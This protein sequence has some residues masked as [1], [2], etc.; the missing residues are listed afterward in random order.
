M[1]LIPNYISDFSATGEKRV[2]GILQSSNQKKYENSLV[3]HSLNY[4]VQIEKKN[5]ISFQYFGETDFLIF[6]PDKGLINIEVKGGGISREGGEWYTTGRAGKNKLKKSP[7]VQATDSMKKIERY[8]E[9]QNIFIPQ[10]FLVVFPDCEFNHD[11]IEW[12][13]DNLCSGNIDQ[14]LIK[15]IINLETNY[16]LQSS[17]RFYPNQETQKKL[18]KIFRSNFE[19]YQSYHTLLKQS[20][21]E[22]NKFTEEQID[23]LD[24]FETNRMLIEGS[25]GTGKT[26]VA[27]EIAK[28]KIA[29]G[30]SVLFLNSNRLAC[31]NIKIKFHE[32]NQK[33]TN[34]IKIDTY[35]G[36]LFNNSQ[37]YFYKSN[38]QDQ[39]YL[40]ANES[41]FFKKNNILTNYYLNKILEDNS[42]VQYDCIIL[43]EI[44]NYYYYDHFYDLIDCLLKDGLRK[45]S[46]Y[47]FG[48]FQFQKL[49]L[50][51]QDLI[52]N[53][54]E[55]K[56]PR[57]NLKD[58]GYYN[59]RLTHNVRNAAEICVQAPIISNV[60]DKHPSMYKNTTG[61]IHHLFASNKKD[62][63][64]ILEN[65]IEKLH[66]NQI[67]GNDIT[68]L[69]PFRLENESNLL[70]H[71]DISRF[72]KIL[73]LNKI[74]NFGDE[75][76]RNK[77]HAN[78]VYFSTTQYFQGMESK[79]IIL[80]DPMF[81]AFGTS[82]TKEKIVKNENLDDRYPENYLT[83]NAMGRANSI[84]Y[85]IWDKIFEKYVMEKKAKSISLIK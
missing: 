59:Q 45:G 28:K 70:K 21:C 60:S 33:K 75:V 12:S 49:F 8:L 3:F 14:N 24:Q 57:N 53:E 76:V 83:F 6:I 79:I 50:L 62:Q 74:N 71:C 5:K 43:D 20:I 65:I 31:E 13:Q 46:W 18:K 85:I 84:L 22:I 27:I 7:F 40:K 81:T 25:Q 73:N 38:P 29:E 63:I 52:D 30:K 35:A 10:A 61:E 9:T 4:P 34:Q 47:F 42:F 77:D 66:K 54:L 36:Y 17:G 11:S 56:H 32:V 44:Q 68:I 26:V 58:F 82:A 15:K 55:V 37:K 51:H 2:F 80:T 1:K 19:S 48:D 16:L 69:S 64:N 23:I 72:Y 39:E 67:S 41:S 78:F